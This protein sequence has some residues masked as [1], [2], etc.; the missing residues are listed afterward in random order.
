VKK[1]LALAALLTACGYQPA[2]SE[3]NQRSSDAKTTVDDSA[4]AVAAEKSS[5]SLVMP[6]FREARRIAALR[7]SLTSVEVAGVA[8]AAQAPYAAGKELF[9][10]DILVGGYRVEVAALDGQGRT[11]LKGYGHVLVEAGAVAVAHVSLEADGADGTGA[12][13]VVIDE[14]AMEPIPSEPM[15][16]PQDP[17][18]FIDCEVPAPPRDPC[19]RRGDCE[20]EASDGAGSDPT[21]VD[22]DAGGSSD[23]GSADGGGSADG[24]GEAADGGTGGADAPAPQPEQPPRKSLPPKASTQG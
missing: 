16:A 22:H 3:G 7:V 13:V 1:L 12:V 24:L 15:P 23:A 5:L 14:D 21:D 10:D 20:G 9:L 18:S 2:E 11:L 6:G 19:S 8:F 17:C 4:D